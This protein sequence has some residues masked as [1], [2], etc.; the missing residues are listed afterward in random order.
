[1]K[2]LGFMVFRIR[3]S[4]KASAACSRFQST[5]QALPQRWSRRYSAHSSCTEPSGRWHM[6]TWPRAVP[7]ITRRPPSLAQWTEAG[8]AMPTAGDA[9]GAD[10]GA[11][12]G[13]EV[14]HAVTAR[15]AAIKKI[16]YT[17]NRTENKE[18][19]PS[20]APCAKCRP[21]TGR[22]QAGAQN[23]YARFMPAIHCRPGAAS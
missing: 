7:S 17:A 6:P 19:Q 20:T 14:P 11:G 23:W 10:A 22:S 4:T 2:R 9:A 5:R 13:A 21:A 12:P 18:R 1:M 3:K 15:Q 8:L 16:L